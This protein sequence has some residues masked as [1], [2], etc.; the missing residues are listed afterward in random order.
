MLIGRTVRHAAFGEGII[1]A[2]DGRCVTVRFESGEKRF[3]YPNAFE[4]YLVA[5]DPD[6]RYEIGRALGEARR[7]REESEKRRIHER[8]C[9]SDKGSVISGYRRAEDVDYDDGESV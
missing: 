1:L 4:G 2:I 7:L 6:V 5:E 9:L 3:V 8:A